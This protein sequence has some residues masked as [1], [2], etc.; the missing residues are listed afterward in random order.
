MVITAVLLLLYTLLL[1][2][3]FQGALF[4]KKIEYLLYFLV[5]LLPIYTVFL[6]LVYQTTDSVIITKIIQYSKEVVIFTFVFT[7]F[8]TR[9]EI[10]A[11]RWEF[12]ILDILFALFILLSLVYL[13]LPVGEASFFNK[14]VYFKNILLMCLM[15]F[16]G[17]ISLFPF[18]RWKK[19]LYLIFIITVAA[20]FVVMWEKV[21]GTHLHSHVGYAKY[22]LDFNDIEMKGYYGL[23]W[24]FEAQGGQKRYG[25]FF[26]D[27]LEFSASLLLSL[28]AAIIF[29]LSVPYHTNRFKYLLLLM[30][31]IASL[32]LA[33]SRASFVAFFMMLFFIGIA[34]KF[35]RLIFAGIAIVLLFVIY[36]WF[37]APQETRFFVED[38]LLFQNSSSLTHLIDWL[39]GI[40]AMIENPM[41]T[42]LAT[43]GNIRGVE[44]DLRIGGEN[45]FLIF[46]VQ[47]GV[48]GLINYF[49][50]YSFAI[51]YSLK[52]YRIA[53]V[54]ED[55]VVPFIAATVKFGLFLPL[56]TANAEAYLYISFISWWMVGYSI[57]TYQR[58]KNL[59]LRQSYLENQ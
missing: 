52:A 20:F 40:N 30:M 49:L 36:V 47:M 28:S 24:T 44:E 31:G 16:F 57:T 41:G 48:A 4:K 56:F 54:R 11:F 39:K 10:F 2:Y 7:L 5:C 53:Q 59:K 50:M 1:W 45:Q 18:S 32:A 8:L 27:P 34:L 38:T 43:S 29:L 58:Y 25:S 22:N 35:Y 9:K 21:N 33:Y 37:F 23:T 15:F 55:Q 26:S 13:V 14:A 17:R 42:G 51:F 3:T 12:N 6:C 46:G 19:A